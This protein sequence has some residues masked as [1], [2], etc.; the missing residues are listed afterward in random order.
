MKAGCAGGSSSPDISHSMQNF[1]KR[2]VEAVECQGCCVMRE[3]L[4][5]ARLELLWN[6][7]T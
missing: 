6:E 4:N 7:Y 3:R 2:T 1:M 5:L